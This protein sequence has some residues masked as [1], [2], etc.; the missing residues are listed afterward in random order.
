MDD[1]RPLAAAS[2]ARVIE[3]AGPVGPAAARNRAAAEA[4]GDI[5]VFVDTDVVVVGDA[6]AGM[7]RLLDAEP[8]IAAVFGAY[9]LQPPEPNFMS[10]YKN[11]SHA[12]IHEMGSPEAETFWAGLG[13]IRTDVFRQVGGFDERFAQPAAEDIDLGYR[14]RRAGYRL[15]LDPSFRGKHL[16]RWTLRSSIVTDIWA[17]GIP[18]TQLIQRYGAA[19]NDLNVRWELR[20]AVVLAYVLVASLAAALVWPWAGLV[21]AGALA[22]LVLIGRRYYAWFVR[23]RGWWFT[24]RVVPAHVLYHLCNGV[25]FALGTMAYLGARVGLRI[26][27]ALPLTDWTSATTASGRNARS[28]C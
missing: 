9:D 18:W 1:C 16:K 19:S 3:I 11:L 23:Q 12:C 4:T 7:C 2:A 5:L 15:R 24:V 10:Q 8:E 25:S 14:V 27:G 20:L 22:M 28:G 13:A 17:R 6:L 21:A 26:P